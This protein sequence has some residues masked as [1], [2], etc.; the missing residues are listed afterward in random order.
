MEPSVKPAP[1]LRLRSPLYILMSYV[2][3][4][5]FFFK[6]SC[7]MTLSEMTYDRLSVRHLCVDSGGRCDQDLSVLKTFLREENATDEDIDETLDLWPTEKYSVN[8]RIK[9]L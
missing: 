4:S 2:L 3:F 1:F 6:S 7:L 8:R 9:L 5:F